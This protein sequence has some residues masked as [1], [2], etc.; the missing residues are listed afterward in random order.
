ML[1]SERKKREKGK[2]EVEESVADATNAG[3]DDDDDLAF[4]DKQIEKAAVAHGRKV[5]GSGKTYH[6]IVNGILNAKPKTVEEKKHP[7]Q[8]NALAMKL[9]AKADDRKKDRTDEKKKK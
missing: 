5:E 3:D 9:K 7:G 6:T 8:A 1:S 2:A 4:L